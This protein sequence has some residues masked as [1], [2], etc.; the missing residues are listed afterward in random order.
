MEKIAKLESWHGRLGASAEWAIPRRVT[1]CD[2]AARPGYNTMLAHEYREDPEVLVEKVKVLAQLI[3]RSKKCVVYSGA[4][5]STSSGISDYASKSGI[6]AS[7]KKKTKLKSPLDAAPTLSHYVL[8]QLFFRKDI[9]RWFNQNHD[10]LPQKCGVPEEHVND[11]HGSWWD[12]S[13][14]VIQF[15]E[16]LR[17]DKFA[18]LLK[19]E[20]DLDLC[21]ALGSSL[22]GMNADRLVTSACESRKAHCA[23]I[24]SLQQRFMT[25][26][27][28]AH[29]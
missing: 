15:N 10:G 12:P 17:S 24:I 1:N 25:F 21:L 5:L 13:N 7:L 8:A 14:P 4:G 19:W 28:T 27:R 3:R 18:D 2:A 29:I 11:I 20:S 26:L 16:S 6:A 23:V 22:C 9:A